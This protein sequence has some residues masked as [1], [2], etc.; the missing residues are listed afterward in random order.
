METAT[1]RIGN[2]TYDNV[3]DYRATM[4]SKM[5]EGKSITT[6]QMVALLGFT[7]GKPLNFAKYEKIGFVHPKDKIND[8]AYYNL[9]FNE[10]GEAEGDPQMVAIYN[11]IRLKGEIDDPILVYPLNRNGSTDILILDGATRASAIAYIQAHDPDAF[12]RVPI[13]VFKGSEEQAMAEMVRLNLDDRSRSLG[14][15]ELMQAIK[16]FVDAGWTKDEISDRLGQD[17]VKWRATLDNFIRVGE[18]LIPELVEAWSA[19][20][21]ARSGAFEAAKTTPEEQETIAEQ[22]NSGEKVTGSQIK[23]RNAEKGEM[24]YNRTL[25]TLAEK[26]SPVSTGDKA[27]QLAGFL[28]GKRL[29]SKFED[30]LVEIRDLITALRDDIDAELNPKGKEGDEE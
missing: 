22:L 23:K 5:L 25:T 10:N 14:D 4:H 15:V 18:S 19:G 17:R 27:S 6:I 26:F 1:L 28:A 2:A 9:T 16:R 20:L 12:A 13:K 21:I 30:R 7:V 29:K 24:R 11:G 8:H 3:N